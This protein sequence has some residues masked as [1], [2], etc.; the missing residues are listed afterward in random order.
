MD[1]NFADRRLVIGYDRRASEQSGRRKGA[2]V[3]ACAGERVAPFV[4]RRLPG[5]RPVDFGNFDAVPAPRL[6]HVKR[7]VSA[8]K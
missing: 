4:L 6:G 7:L 2:R 5:A 8:G 3:D 1:S